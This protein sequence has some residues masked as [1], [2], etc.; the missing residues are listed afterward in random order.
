MSLRSIA[1]NLRW[2]YWLGGTAALLALGLGAAELSGWPFLQQPLARA[3]TRAAGVPVQF[4]GAFELRLLRPPQLSVDHLSVGAGQGVP[5]GHLVQADALRVQWRWGE[6][7]RTYRGEPLA[8]RSLQAGSL[9]ASLMRQ[10][11]GSASWKFAHAAPAVG[12]PR[13]PRIEHLALQHALLRVI[14]EPTDTRAVITLDSDDDGVG[15][16]AVVAGTYRAVPIDLKAHADQ[17]LALFSTRTKDDAERPVRVLVQGSV[18][19]SKLRF[20]GT[21]DAVLSAYH[22][23][24][25]LQLSGP[26]LAAVGAPLGITLPRTPAFD[27]EGRLSHNDTQWHLLARHFK[28][29]RS[30]LGGDFVFDTAL[31]PHKLSGRLTGQRLVLSDLGPALGT[32]GEGAVNAPKVAVKTAGASHV[33][34]DRQFNLPS[35]RAMQAELSVA[36]DELDFGSTAIAPLHAFRTEVELKD[37]VLKLKALQAVVAGGR[38]AGTSSLD[39]RNDSAHWAADLDFKGVDLA[40]WLR[41]VR[42]PAAAS[43]PV[44]TQARALQRERLAALEPGKQ[45]LQAWVTGELAGDMHLVGSGRSTAQILGSLGGRASASLRDGTVSHLAIEAAG[46]DAAQALG[47]MMRGDRPL[48]LNCARVELTFEQGVATL[49]RAVVDNRDSTIFFSG[50]VNLRDETLALKATV[51]PKDISPFTLRTP[52]LV[53]GTLAHPQ[54]RI[55][56]RALATKALFAALLGAISGPAALLPFIDLGAKVE[57]DPCTA[58][59]TPA[60]AAA[61]TSTPTRKR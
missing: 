20:D 7:W 40:G 34:P 51:K 1:T 26:S 33:L 38:I 9:D 57:G 21:A 55:E 48:P 29:G 32:T 44:P 27:L 14:D 23:D 60:P 53:G 11:D 12:L 42:T 25:A 36:I 41:A 6:L 30:S 56:G 3:L 4:G 5:V 31:T 43:A 54:V 24:G 18:G 10:A 59:T 8:L 50:Q 52:L 19:A 58:V 45:P 39:G 28:V 49:R 15:I 13:L 16:S 61:S 22:L 47:V 37:A 46:L 2:P 35:L 17:A